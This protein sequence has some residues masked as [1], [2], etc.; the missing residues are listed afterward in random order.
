[1]RKEKE[2]LHQEAMAENSEGIVDTKV[3]QT[4]E[5]QLQL[6]THFADECCEWELRPRV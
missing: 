3:S 6:L 1:V 5:Q 2:S 4:Q